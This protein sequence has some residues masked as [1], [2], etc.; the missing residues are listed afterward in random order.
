MP[1]SLRS[2]Y[3]ADGISVIWYGLLF[4]L[5]GRL[6]HPQHAVRGRDLWQGL[7]LVFHAMG[8]D[9]ERKSSVGAQLQASVRLSSHGGVDL[10]AWSE[11]GV[12][13][14][15]RRI[16][17]YPEHGLNRE[18][19]YWLAALLAVDESCTGSES[20]PPGVRHLLQ[21]VAATQRLL[22]AFPNLHE[23]YHRLCAQELMLRR[24][25]YPD[26]SIG[27]RNPS[28]VLESAIRSELGADCGCAHDSLNEMIAQAKS[29]R[30]I[31]ANSQWVG[32]TVPFL[33][34]PLWRYR[35]VSVQKLRIPFLRGTRKRRQDASRQPQK[36]AIFDIDHV[37]EPEPG[38]AAIRDHY[39]YPEWNYLTHTYMRNW[40]RLIEQKPKGGYHAE[41][42]SQFSELVHRVRRRFSLL[43]QEPQWNRFLEDGDELDIDTYVTCVADRVGCG[44]LRSTY[45]RQKVHQFRDISVIIL[46]DAS[47]STEAWV[48]KNRVIDIAKQSMAV[49]AEV[50]DSVADDFALYAFS[51]DSRLRVRCDRI[52]TFDEKYD[53]SIRHNLLEVKPQNYTRMGPV[54][55]HLGAKLQARKSRQK[56]LIILSDG[57]PHDP[58][59]QYEGR[60][61]LEDT[62]KA[63]MEQRSRNVMCFGLTIDQSGPRYLNRLFGPGHY[64]VYSHLH[65]LPDVLPGLYARLTDLKLQ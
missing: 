8:G 6:R 39:T 26:P 38:L 52:K 40:C 11:P 13:H 21:G 25:A 56:L 36:T 62:R 50:L 18:L 7:D 35:S 49:L 32:V 31:V 48:G 14:L 10:Q 30:P 45:F 64:A 33:P 9:L 42:D 61:A 65:S 4:G 41:L 58:T 46:M 63:L 3:V 43:R 29:G 44:M 17:R 37:A 34:V 5:A 55:R 24:A 27:T 22:T 19:Y 2:N 60:Y 12:L 15:P 51:S 53:E 28:L 57:K 1:T 59:D 20:L 54:V 16:N 23:R 47:R